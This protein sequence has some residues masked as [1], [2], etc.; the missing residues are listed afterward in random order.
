MEQTLQIVAEQSRTRLI[1]KTFF[2]QKEG[3]SVLVQKTTTSRP[4]HDR[5]SLLVVS[6]W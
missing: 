2:V 6:L 1:A 4:K 5:K 3:G